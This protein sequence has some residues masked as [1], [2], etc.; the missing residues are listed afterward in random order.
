MANETETDIAKNAWTVVSFKVGYGPDFYWQISPDDS[1]NVQIV[2]FE[3]EYD[4]APFIAKEY[5]VG[6]PVELSAR[7]GH[8]IQVVSEYIADNPM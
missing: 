4:G 1:N 2:Y 7:I 8:A 3:R 5:M 6:W